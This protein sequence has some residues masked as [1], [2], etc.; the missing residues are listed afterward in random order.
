[1]YYIYNILSGEMVAK[2]S[3][4]MSLL[5]AWARKVCKVTMWSCHGSLNEVSNAF[6]DLSMTNSDIKVY[7][8]AMFTI[9]TDV[10]EETRVLRTHRVYDSAGRIIDIRLWP[11]CDEIL[12]PPRKRTYFCYN[13]GHK[14]HGHRVSGPSFNHRD[15]RDRQ[16]DDYYGAKP[17]RISVVDAWDF[18][19]KRYFAGYC[20]SKSWKDQTKSRKQWCKHKTKYEYSSIKELNSIYLANKEEDA[21]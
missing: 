1:M 13:L 2:A 21:A 16:R 14:H 11:E 4:K 3:D 15:L 5:R 7:R 17:I 10:I 9:S 18:S 8:R 19:E 6:D 20:K 12:F